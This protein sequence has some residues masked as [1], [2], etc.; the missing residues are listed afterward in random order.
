[1]RRKRHKLFG[2]FGGKSKIAPFYPSPRFDTI[3][4]PFAGAANYSNLYYQKQVILYEVNPIIFG[5]LDF[6]IKA[7]PQEILD[8]PL[9]ESGYEVKDLDTH[10]EGKW[11]I[12]MNLN[13]ATIEPSKKVAQFG[14]D[15]PHSLWGKTRRG[16]LSIIVKQI[17]HWKVYNKSARIAFQEHGEK[18]DVTWFID[19]PY[20][21]KMGNRYPYGSR[22][23]NYKKLG[24]VIL[25]L[26]GQ[27]IVCEGEGA[28]W[29]PFHR[30]VKN[31]R[32]TYAIP[33]WEMIWTRNCL[34]R[35]TLF[36]TEII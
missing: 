1:M 2:Y 25:N 9:F 28:T 12:G 20:E 24:K 17:K 13:L 19:P 3:I 35:N 10:Q 31:T 6:L 18:E 14:F 11:L 15:R 32:T 30:L 33:G 4:E 36:G 26:K 27:L 22:N 16:R 7:T 23:I 8:L 5:V 34:T 21:K 29:L